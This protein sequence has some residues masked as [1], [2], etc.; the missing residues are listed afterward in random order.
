MGP[1]KYTPN[2]EKNFDPNKTVFPIGEKSSDPNFAKKTFEKFRQEQLEKPAERMPQGEVTVSNPV[3]NIKRNPEE[4]RRFKQQ[5]A[6]KLQKKN[7]GNP[8]PN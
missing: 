1:E 6:D 4:M 7:D 2:T 5:V 8:R 3:L